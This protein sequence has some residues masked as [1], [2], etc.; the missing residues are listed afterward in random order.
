MR[1]LFTCFIILFVFAGKAQNLIP[2]PGFEEYTKCPTQVSE[3]SKAKYWKSATKGT[4]DYY[5][6]C[7]SAEGYSE[8]GVPLNR[9]GTMQPKSGNA[10][11]GLIIFNTVNKDTEREY[12]QA[13]FIQPMVEG[14]K[15]CIQ[16][17][18]C[19][20][21]NSTVSSDAIE[22]YIS[23]KQ[24]SA[25]KWTQLPYSPQ[26]QNKNGIIGDMDN[27]TLIK[28]TYTSIGNEQ[29]LTIGNFKDARHV[30][31][32][33]T[34][35]SLYGYSYYYI[36][37]I[38]AIDVTD[39]AG[40]ADETEDTSEMVAAP[41]NIKPDSITLDSSIV[42]KNVFFETDKAILQA[43]SYT[44][45]NKL[46]AYLNS[47]P[48]YHIAIS[49]YTDSVSN[50]SHN[51]KLSEARAQSVTE[52]LISKGLDEK[53]ITYKGYGNTYPRARNNTPEGRQENRRVEFKLSDPQ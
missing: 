51:I 12:I 44:E 40:Y 29:Y 14:R 1:T 10:Y 48:T 23:E 21:K 34:H 17:Y 22:A 16:F 26:I 18:V 45:L 27:W 32:K 36:D 4:P 46:S 49:G 50:D 13:K 24:V 37:D 30:N 11:V 20:A 38:T 15:Y 25:K 53:R 19:L 28:G 8:A 35:H 9:M 6:T 52:Y 7:A 47:H 5:C 33:P 3:L 41:A 31:V 42:L 39:S 43:V 2:N